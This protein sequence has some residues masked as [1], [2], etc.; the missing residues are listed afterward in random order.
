MTTALKQAVKELRDRS[1]ICLVGRASSIETTR[2]GTH[3]LLYL[4]LEASSKVSCCT[5]HEYEGGYILMNPQAKNHLLRRT[6]KE[7][8]ASMGPLV[9]HIPMHLAAIEQTASIMLTGTFY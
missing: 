1:F 8:S 4:R 7:Q 2:K 6:P 3:Y 5:L 9:M